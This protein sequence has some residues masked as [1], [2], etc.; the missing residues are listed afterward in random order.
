MAQEL[1]N[2]NTKMDAAVIILLAIMG[3]FFAIDVYL[4]ITS[5]IKF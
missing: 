5:G 4:F 1:V 3:L 2:E